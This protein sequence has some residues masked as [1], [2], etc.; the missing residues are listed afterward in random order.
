MENNKSK[1]DSSILRFFTM[2]S[3]NM[4]NFVLGELDPSSPLNVKEDQLDLVVSDSPEDVIAS[5]AK[6]NPKK[7][8]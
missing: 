5:R 1:S 4:Q 7:R 2:I 8:I 6:L 3:V